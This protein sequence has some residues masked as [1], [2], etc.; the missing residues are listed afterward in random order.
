MMSIFEENVKRNI[1]YLDYAVSFPLQM[2]G[3]LCLVPQREK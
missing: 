1:I 2:E 3:W